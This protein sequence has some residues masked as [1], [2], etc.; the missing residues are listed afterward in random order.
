MACHAMQHTTCSV[1]FVCGCGC[2]CVRAPHRSVAS[3]PLSC[4]RSCVRSWAFAMNSAAKTTSRSSSTQP[5][6]RGWNRE[7]ARSTNARGCCLACETI[8]L[9]R[10][11][12]G[13]VVWL[14]V[15][16]PSHHRLVCCAHLPTDTASRRMLWRRQRRQDMTVSNNCKP[17]EAKWRSSKKTFPTFK[18]CVTWSGYLVVCCFVLFPCCCWWGRSRGCCL[19]SW[20]RLV[21]LVSSRLVSSRLMDAGVG[22]CEDRGHSSPGGTRRS[23]RRGPVNRGAKEGDRWGAGGDDIESGRCGC[24]LCVEQW[25]AVWCTLG[26]GQLAGWLAWLAA[27]AAVVVVVVAACTEQCLGW[28]LAQGWMR[29]ARIGTMCCSSSFRMPIACTRSWSLSWSELMPKQ[30]GRKRKWSGFESCLPGRVS[31]QMTQTSQSKAEPSSAN[32]EMHATQ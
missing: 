9:T 20:C 32:M 4:T 2:V 6:D 21:R 17:H 19:T 1:H 7:C 5:A 25:K 11:N 24:V 8:I 13:G 22:V 26:C 12:G 30:L 16:C 15:L 29:R 3:W 31:T 28:P 23:S 18:W 14:V 10:T 27:A